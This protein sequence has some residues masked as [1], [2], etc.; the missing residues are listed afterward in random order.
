MSAT[1]PSKATL[2]KYG[3]TEKEWLAIWESQGSK[4]PIC[5]RSPPEVKLH[6][7]HRHVRNYKKMP[8]EARKLYVRGILCAYDNMNFL[9]V[10]MTL[11]KARNIVAYLEAFDAR[12]PANDNNFVVKKPRKKKER[13]A[14][15]RKG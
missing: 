13:K 1:P 5:G 4:C 7:D 9:P 12:K 15:K 10:G 14:P 8:S 2:S 6:C 3:I 11:E